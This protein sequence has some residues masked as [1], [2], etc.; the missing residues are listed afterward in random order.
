MKKS[1]RYILL[2]AAACGAF[3]AAANNSITSTIESSVAV[4]GSYVNLQIQ[5]VE[6]QGSQSEILRLTDMWPKEVELR[7]DSTTSVKEIGNG[8]QEV[9]RTY[10]LQS[11]DSGVYVIPP[12]IHIVGADTAISNTITLKINPIDVSHMEDIHPMATVMSAGSKWYDFLPDWLT[13]N[14]KW[15][16]AGIILLAAGI[17]TVLILTNRLKVPFLPEKKVEPPYDQAKRLL[18]ML[19]EEHLWEKGHDKEYYSELTDILRRYISRRYDVNAL[20]MTSSQ[21]LKH[22]AEIPEIA[23]ELPNVKAVLDTADF[24]KFA[25]MQPKPEVNVKAYDATDEFIENTRPAEIAEDD[26]ATSTAG[27]ETNLKPEN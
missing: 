27:D 15:L 14:W 20:E 5:A 18:A 16:L 2:S 19:K 11:F 6:P 26:N 1:L 22:L 25:K 23:A 17:V 3:Y 24:V 7:P 10:K 13:D 21:L 4:M 12:F 8:L 9:T